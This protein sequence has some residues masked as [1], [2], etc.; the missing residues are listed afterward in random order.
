M[1]IDCKFKNLDDAGKSYILTVS[2]R[3]LY[4]LFSCSLHSLKPQPLLQ[5]R[6]SHQLSCTI[7]SSC[8]R[9]S[10]RLLV[11]LHVPGGFLLLAARPVWPLL[12]AR[13]SRAFCPLL[14]VHPAEV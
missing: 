11:P 1:G 14:P 9:R 3:V 8:G 4:K 5:P 12:L 2:V 6:V 10:P 7:P 13:P